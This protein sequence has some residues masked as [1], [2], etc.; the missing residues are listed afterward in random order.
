MP[1][2]G[3]FSVDWEGLET[4]CI[5]VTYQQLNGESSGSIGIR[6]FFSSK[7]LTPISFGELCRGHW[8][9]KNHEHAHV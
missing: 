2:I 3:D 7:E 1:G 8:A 4:L 6:Y 9:G 5:A